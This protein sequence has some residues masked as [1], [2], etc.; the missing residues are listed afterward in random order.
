M[1]HYVPWIGFLISQKKPNDCFLS[2]FLI[3]Q[4]IVLH[5][6]WLDPFF[7]VW[8]SNFFVSDRILKTR[9]IAYSPYVGIVIYRGCRNAIND[10]KSLIKLSFFQICRFDFFFQ[11]IKKK[12]LL[13]EESSSEKLSTPFLHWYLV[14]PKRPEIFLMKFFPIWKLVFLQN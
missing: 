10:H 11:T 1:I 4:T 9:N 14:Y 2:Y 13:F 8:I 5:N 7:K 6:H 12:R 3:F